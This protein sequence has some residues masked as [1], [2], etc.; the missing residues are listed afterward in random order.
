MRGF[1]PP[2]EAASDA[3]PSGFALRGLKPLQTHPRR[4]RRFP[5]IQRLV[6]GVVVCPVR[7]IAATEQAF[8]D[9]FSVLHQQT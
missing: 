7:A 1:Q 4:P 2:L 8:K 3:L 6:F 9:G 5:S